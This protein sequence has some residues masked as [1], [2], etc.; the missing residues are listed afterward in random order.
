MERQAIELLIEKIDML[1]EI[2][3]KMKE[4]E[5]LSAKL[6]TQLLSKHEQESI[7]LQI[8]ELK[9]EINYLSSWFEE[10]AH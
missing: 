1:L 6:A 9:K 8:E 10:G 5:A 4:V 3:I 2:D 7:Y